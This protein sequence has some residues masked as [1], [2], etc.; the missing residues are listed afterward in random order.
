MY[1]C[2]ATLYW[3]GC[4]RPADSVASVAIAIAL[5]T[6]DLMIRL[7]WSICCLVSMRAHDC[8][9]LD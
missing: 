8:A 9:A 6:S 2:H 3:A 4:N 1:V 7:A 5:A